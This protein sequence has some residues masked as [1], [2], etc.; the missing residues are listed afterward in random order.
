MWKSDV[1]ESAIPIGGC[2]VTLSPFVFKTIFCL[3]TAQN[4]LPFF[5]FSLSLSLSSAT[6]GQNV[7]NSQPKEFL[8]LF[9][10]HDHF[11]PFQTPW[12]YLVRRFLLF[13]QAAQKKKKY[14]RQL[15][16]LVAVKIS[17]APFLRVDIHSA[18]SLSFWASK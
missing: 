5:L 10:Q 18:R 16:L 11:F 15:I 4:Y 3:L 9:L 1:N 8:A 17:Y 13:A 6:R 7:H 2:F 14:L 12:W